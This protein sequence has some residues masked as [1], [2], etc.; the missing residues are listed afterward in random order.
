MG[1]QRIAAL[2][3]ELL[4]TTKSITGAAALVGGGLVPF[5]I[6]A[7]E[8]VDHTT[9]ITKGLLFILPA[10]LLFSLVLSWNLSRYAEDRR[11]FD[12]KY[13]LLST[14]WSFT[15]NADGTTLRGE[16][17]G[18]RQILC[19]GETLEYITIA[20]GPRENLIPIDSSDTPS[21]ELD[22]QS[23]HS[24][25]EIKMR[26]PHRAEA[27]SLSFRVD[28]YPPLKE[29][30]EA[31]VRFRLVLPRHKISNL[32]YLRERC[33]TA[34]LDARDFECVA[35]TISYP[36]DR[37]LYELR[38]APECRI[39]PRAPDAFRGTSIVHSETC[40]LRKKQ[41][42]SADRLPDGGWILRLD[43]AKPP[44]NTR[45]RIS[46]TPPSW[47][48]LESTLTCRENMRIAGRG[49]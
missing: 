15:L 17:T 40:E 3:V 10:L 8:L 16:C 22:P 5:V 30:D 38:F 4:S 35:W 11:W 48:E 18:E 33:Q 9:A 6:Y 31:Y 23:R 39:K 7:L 43:R 2:K 26:Q 42:F 46:W 29:G 37:F 27:G 21:V 25:G 24:N 14:K 49:T 32:D 1:G 34:K 44:I 41:V 28:F 19:L 12:R 45:Y 36:T 13:G 47:R 20:V